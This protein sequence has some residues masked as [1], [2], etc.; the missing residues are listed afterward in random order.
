[1]PVSAGESAGQRLQDLQ[2]A[3]AKI[4]DAKNRAR[5]AQPPQHLQHHPASAGAPPPLPDLGFGAD[6]HT[7]NASAEAT[8]F[9]PSDGLLPH[10]SAPLSAPMAC[11]DRP[12]SASTEFGAAS[13]GPF[14]ANQNLWASH[15]YQHPPASQSPSASYHLPAPQFAP[16]HQQPAFHGPVGPQYAQPPCPP[17]PS[18]GTPLELFQ[19][20]YPSSAPLEFQPA[21]SQ[22]PPAYFLELQRQI[23][24]MKQAHER[25]LA[26][27]ASLI[28]QLRVSGVA[29]TGPPSV[30]ESAP[31]VA[32]P[33]QPVAAAPAQ[34]AQPPL[35]VGA[36]DL[37]S[38]G[39]A[40]P[41]LMECDLAA[42]CMSDLV[43]DGKDIPFAVSTLVPGCTFHCDVE[44]VEVTPTD[45]ILVEWQTQQPSG[46]RHGVM[47]KAD[48]ISIIRY[49][50]SGLEYTIV[51]M[52]TPVL[53]KGDGSCKVPDEWERALSS[54]AEQQDMLDNSPIREAAA[55][56]VLPSIFLLGGRQ[57]IEV[58]SGVLDG[59]A[60]G[61]DAHYKDVINIGS[62]LLKEIS[63]RV[64]AMVTAPSGPSNGTLEQLARDCFNARVIEHIPEPGTY[65]PLCRHF[66]GEMEELLAA[67]GSAPAMFIKRVLAMR[68]VH[69][70]VPLVMLS[71]SGL[72]RTTLELDAVH[73]DVP[74]TDRAWLSSMSFKGSICVHSGAAN[75]FGA[76]YN[77]LLNQ[78]ELQLTRFLG[79]EHRAPARLEAS[80][81]Q[82]DFPDA[83]RLSSPVVLKALKKAKDT[84]QSFGIHLAAQDLGRTPSIGIDI[85]C[86]IAGGA[87]GSLVAEKAFSENMKKNRVLICNQVRLALAHLARLSVNNI[88]G[89]KIAR[90][91][92]E[93]LLD[94]L[95]ALPALQLVSRSGRLAEIARI[96]VSSIENCSASS[97]PMPQTG[98]RSTGDA[99]QPRRRAKAAPGPSR[100]SGGAVTKPRS[101]HRQG[102]RVAAS[103]RSPSASA[104]ATS[105]SLAASPEHAS[106]PPDLTAEQSRDV[107][108]PVANDAAPVAAPTKEQS[109]AA[110]PMAEDEP[111]E[112]GTPMA[113]DEPTEHG[114]PMAEDEPAEHGTPMADDEPA[115]HGTPVQSAASTS[116]GPADTGSAAPDSPA[117]SFPAVPLRVCRVVE[118]DEDV[119][120]DPDDTSDEACIAL[121]R[122]LQASDVPLI[123]V[124]KEP[125]HSGKEEFYSAGARLRSMQQYDSPADNE[126]A[127]WSRC[128]RFAALV[129]SVLNAEKETRQPYKDV[130]IAGAVNE[131]MSFDDHPDSA[132]LYENITVKPRIPGEIFGGRSHMLMK[133][134]LLRAYMLG[135][136]GFREMLARA[137]KDGHATFADIFPSCDASVP[138][139]IS[140]RDDRVRR[141]Q[142]ILS[143][144]V[145]RPS[146]GSFQY[147]VLKLIRNMPLVMI[148]I[149]AF[150]MEQQDRDSLAA[151]CNGLHMRAVGRSSSSEF[152]KVIESP[153][154]GMMVAVT[155][156]S[157]TQFREAH[158]SLGHLRG[159]PPDGRANLGV[160]SA[161][162]MCVPTKK[163]QEP[164]NDENYE[165]ASIAHNIVCAAIGVSEVEELLGYV[166]GSPT[167]GRLEKLESAAAGFLNRVH[168]Q[169]ADPAT[170][171]RLFPLFANAYVRH[172]LA[173]VL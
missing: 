54:Y 129:C 4:N 73:T 80:R 164:I 27:Q 144:N 135:R 25:Q 132:I 136:E 151:L 128:G 153:G 46:I 96:I 63:E 120:P 114:T 110:E 20:P 165:V 78:Y 66:V 82:L 18:Y 70:V 156:A 92:V 31:P 158:G 51:A 106:P 141:I 85:V 6:S 101:G 157:E 34:P 91:M 161:K 113:E 84:M 24:T 143:T 7:Y 173:S 123:S 81:A 35:D 68:E 147:F 108:S 148:L 112:H 1:M 168:K 105:Q 58:R 22:Q 32:S 62:I 14:A 126:Q 52:A 169:L 130:L 100:T 170:A 49:G 74:S 29:T 140:D 71:L 43:P 38:G 125:R 50:N 72:G 109:P 142:S 79:Y 155:L 40:P 17:G 90:D 139:W 41:L 119:A 10:S 12:F 146:K 171:A 57:F 99:R 77:S 39:S 104:P 28:Q 94:R 15:S 13:T 56:G 122:Q 118:A 172:E 115:E 107:Y 44:A 145:L 93:K 150:S 60:S 166:A 59:G 83:G 61:R 116:P 124:K 36:F 45:C 103:S 11:N 95:E 111:T 67:D 89:A 162:G 16:A 88:N 64:V 138:T 75:I 127:Y 163:P 97:A 137:I 21:S 154:L 26:E 76:A 19:E 30:P 102:A 53:V 8:L 65:Q 98:H 152:N 23:D 121:F 33:I 69:G 3:F 37:I 117:P 5:H 2:D 167:Y 149:S 42:F 131:W 47:M 86:I 9:P 87:I 160:S 133:A 48:I 134:S 55:R 159:K